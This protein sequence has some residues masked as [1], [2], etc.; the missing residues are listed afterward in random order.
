MYIYESP[1]GPLCLTAKNGLITGLYFEDNG[2]VPNANEETVLRAASLELDAYFAG[3]LKVFTVPFRPAGTPFRMKVWE[4][5]C[6]I[7]YG[8]T[9]TYKQLAE[10]IGLPSAYRAVGGANHNNPISIIIPCHR[11]IGTGGNLVG[12]GGGLNAKE[13]LLK[14]EGII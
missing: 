2:I 6:T 7:P 13:W 1:I 9:I 4:A 11:V 10:R 12:Y 5:L 14:H 8:E 3:K